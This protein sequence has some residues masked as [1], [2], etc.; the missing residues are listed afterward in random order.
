MKKQDKIDEAD[1]GHVPVDPDPGFD[2]DRNRSVI[3]EV[4][5]ESESNRRKKQRQ[6]DE[7]LGERAQA[8]AQYLKS[9]QKGGKSSNVEQYFGKKYLAHLVG[10]EKIKQ[11]KNAQKKQK[12]QT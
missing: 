10:R 2:A 6:F 1:W 7:Q 12:G 8:T 11:L 3:D 4:I 5:A 9:L